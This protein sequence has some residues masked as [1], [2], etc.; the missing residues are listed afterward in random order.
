MTAERVDAM[1]DIGLDKLPMKPRPRPPDLQLPWTADQ[2]PEDP[3][4]QTIFVTDLRGAPTPTDWAVLSDYMR[5]Y[6]QLTLDVQ[7]HDGGIPDLEFLAGFEW[8][9]C[10]DI[11]GWTI[12]SFDGLRHVPR[13]RTLS[14]S[15]SKRRV[16]LDVLTQLPALAHLAITD[17]SRDVDVLSDIPTLRS[18]SLTSVKRDN[19][20]FLGGAQQLGALH[21]TQGRFNDL[22]ALPSLPNLQML[23]MY[24]TKVT[25]LAPI[26]DCLQLAS[27]RLEGLPVADVPDLHKLTKLEVVQ[28]G[29]LKDFRDL[30]PIAAAPDL[31]YLRVESATLQPADFR[32]LASHPRLEYLDANLKTDALS[33]QTN[34]VVG[35]PRDIDAVYE[36]DFH[37][38]L[39]SR[40]HENDREV[41]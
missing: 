36:N 13:L 11:V 31:R 14:L 18:I 6:P 21:T 29:K 32:V 39:V 25:E 8:L 26:G 10:L 37:A 34:D 1:S 23:S 24:R 27:L 2:L 40:I 7:S 41:P 33:Y 12:E 19:L 30:A 16:P 22:S 3:E 5:R 4:F 38:K 28:I 17:H 20:D 9:T 35:R 15:E